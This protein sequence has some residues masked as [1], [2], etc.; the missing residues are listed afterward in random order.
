MNSASKMLGNIEL[1]RPSPAPESTCL[2]EGSIRKCDATQFLPL[3]F[4]WLNRRISAPQASFRQN[5]TSLFMMF[6]YQAYDQKAT[7]SGYAATGRYFI[8][9]TIAQIQLGPL[10]DRL[11]LSGGAV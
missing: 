1:A 3:R 7:G 11:T 5:Y 8:Q 4:A 9:A 2:K 10:R 6:M